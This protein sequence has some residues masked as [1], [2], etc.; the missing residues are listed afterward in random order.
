MS[1]S[2]YYESPHTQNIVKTRI[3]SK[4][5]KAWSDIMLTHGKDAKG[6]IA[7]IDLFSGPGRFD[8]RTASTPLWLLSQAVKD[9]RL[10]SRLVTLFNDKD[11][12]LID[13]LQT[14]IDAFPGIEKLTY[15]PQLSSVSVGSEIATL[16]RNMNL[17][18]TLFFID[19]WGFKGLSL[20][21]VGATIKS[22]GCD[23]IFFFNYNRV[24]Q[25]LHAEPVE[26][27]INELF[28][29]E[30]A[31]R[32]RQMLKGAT[33]EKR[34]E[35]I[36]SELILALKEVG[37]QYVLPFEFESRYGERTSHYIIFVSKAKRGYLIMRDV[38][39]KMS[40]GDGEVKSFGYVPVRSSQ[41]NL[42]LDL[43]NPYSIP[44]LKR[45]LLTACAGL[46]ITVK[47]VH[48]DYTIDTPYIL[49]LVQTAI[50][51]LEREGLV[52]VSV[53]AEERRAPKGVL[54]LAPHL[55]VTFPT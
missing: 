46:S 38:M 55:T 1:T 11:K 18:P 44:A 45:L 49:K 54:T 39:Y 17:V 43:E 29:V 51:D 15:K 7:Y 53:P 36:T 24:N 40:S 9:L 30:R 47:Q 34:K 48:E 14:E 2:G 8:D 10:C 3:V 50:K 35:T 20:D 12:T 41:L 26:E 52:K 16:Y 22:W 23:C 6:R 25:F 31:N 5:F 4:Y 32:L 37:G 28:G 21:L 19:P 13:R 27:E 42:L 33:S